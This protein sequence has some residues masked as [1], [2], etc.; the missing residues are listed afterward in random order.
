M[1]KQSAL[2]LIFGNQLKLSFPTAEWDWW[3]LLSLIKGEPYEGDLSPTHQSHLLSDLGFLSRCSP[4][5]GFM[6]L[7]LVEYTLLLWV[8][9]VSFFSLSEFNINERTKE[10]ESEY[11]FLKFFDPDS[12]LRFSNSLNPEQGNSYSFILCFF[13]GLFRLEDP[14][15]GKT[16]RYEAAWLRRRGSVGVKKK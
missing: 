12:S 13:F 15:G 6:E 3:I 10:Q 5:D 4:K 11:G 8:R 7:K 1:S 9:K 14:N 16:E 2:E